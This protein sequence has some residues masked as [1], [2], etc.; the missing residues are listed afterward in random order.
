[1]IIE[2]VRRAF[3]VLNIFSRHRTQVGVTEIA[4]ALEVTKGTAH[5][6]VSTLVECGLLKQDP[7]SRKYFLGLK[8]F[9]LASF[10]P[11]VLVLNEN[12]AGPSLELARTKRLIS[13]VGVWDEEAALIT[14]TNYPD[15]SPELT[16]SIGP[17]VHAYSSA[18]GKAM[19]AYLPEA[20]LVSYLDRTELTPFTQS[21]ITDRETLL[22]ELKETR[23]CGLAWDREESVIGTACL[24]TP[25]FGA[26]D[27]V[28]GAL[29]LSGSPNRL[30]TQKTF[31]YISQDL[32]RTAGEISR[33][34][35]NIPRVSV[36]ERAE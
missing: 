24:G 34:L 7:E 23:R 28:I 20:E 32:L 19:L 33:R 21:T 22:V 29:S 9:E 15:N 6:L 14:M 26:N 1:M 10:Q 4:K 36:I 12:A 3:A 25:L 16:R 30:L 31:E 17:R 35:G 2:S 27:R 13:R 8:T 18:L 5:N 11:E